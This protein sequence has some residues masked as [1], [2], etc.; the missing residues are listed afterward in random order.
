MT[1]PRIAAV[2][3]AAGRATRFGGGKL[4]ADLGGKSVARHAADALAAL[5]FARRIAICSEQTPELPH[6]FRLTLTPPDA[7]LSRSIATAIAAL[8]DCDAALFAL[9]DMPL[10]PPD[11]FA[12]LLDVFDGDA[13][14][15]R[16]NGRA[17]VPAIFGREHFAVLAA[18]T[19]D[20]G[21]GA[22]LADAPAIDLEP[23]LALDVDTPEDLARAQAL[24]DGAQVRL[25]APRCI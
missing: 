19:G 7:P 4:G 8:D 22:L 25:G 6:F 18:L 24:R 14:A 11:H 13:V 16:V 9:A 23:G 3:L 15:T 12:R 1:G 5:P 20:R 21:A 2:L 17:M 10:V